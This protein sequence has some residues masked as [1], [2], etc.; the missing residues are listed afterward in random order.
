[1]ALVEVHDVYKTY[2]KDSQGVQVFAGVNLE[3]E[4]GEYLAL[5]GRREAAKA[6]C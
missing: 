2:R 1:M 6:L 4:R 3:I 5:M